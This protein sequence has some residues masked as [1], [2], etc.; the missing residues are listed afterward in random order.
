MEICS[1]KKWENSTFAVR[2]RRQT[3]VTESTKLKK[4]GPII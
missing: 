4:I 1:D 2:D 3:P